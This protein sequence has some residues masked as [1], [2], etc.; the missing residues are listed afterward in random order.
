M[1]V[2]WT[3]CGSSEV[4]DV[5]SYFHPRKRRSIVVSEILINKATVT[6][7]NEYCN[8][9]MD[10]KTRRKIKEAQHTSLV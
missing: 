1:T 8:Y 3:L 4:E 9:D 7:L 10:G 2:E 5:E 6:F